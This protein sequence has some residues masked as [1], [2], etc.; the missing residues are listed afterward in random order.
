MCRGLCLSCFPRFSPCPV[1]A[2]HR[3]PLGLSGPVPSPA[4]ADCDSYWA[5]PL[6]YPPA[7]AG[8]RSPVI[9]P[10]C[11]PSLSGSV[12]FLLW[13]AA[14]CYSYWAWA[15][16]CRGGAPASWS[17][18]GPCPSPLRRG[19]RRLRPMWFPI[20]SRCGGA[21]AFRDYFGLRPLLAAAGH[22]ALV[23]PRDP[24]PYLLRRGFGFWWLSWTRTHSCCGGAPAF[25]DSRGT[26]LPLLRRGTGHL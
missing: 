3:A 19:T 13:A 8:L 10:F 15:P 17:P 23:T 11:V 7:V 2:G 4:A 16:P 14:D 20:P 6:L 25:C 24:S 9:S 12:P 26:G 1:P 5:W 18:F 22:R 21:P